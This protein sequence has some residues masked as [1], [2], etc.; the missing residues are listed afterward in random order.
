MITAAERE[1]IPLSELHVD[2]D[3]PESKL[4]NFAK[5]LSDL[6]RSLPDVPLTIT[7]LP[8]WL[9]HRSEFR[10]L[11]ES[12]SSYVLQVHSLERPHGSSEN[13]VLC[14]SE[15]AL[16][17]VR[18]A[19][20]FGKPF[21]VAL[22]TYSYLIAFDN[23][24]QFAGI[25][26]EQSWSAP[27]SDT[28]VKE[29]RSLPSEMARLVRELGNCHIAALTGVI[30]Y[31]LP[32]SDDQ[33]N[34]SWATLQSVTAG[35]SPVSSLKCEA[36][37]IRPALYEVILRNDG[38]EQFEGPLA[39]RLTAPEATILARDALGSFQIRDS[40][41]NLVVLESKD[42]IQPL[43]PLAQRQ[44]GWVRVGQQSEVQFETKI[45]MH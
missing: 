23:K 41:Q 26:A 14:D 1:N 7:T 30:W 34:W 19:G 44:I 29:V 8:A 38:S 35:Q 39:V 22:P 32:T 5:L 15:S 12:V 27:K 33:L 16:K 13:L 28:L 42:P 17:A 25:R 45:T 31:R 11:T 3:C 36:R 2:F 10:K 18:T 21:L 40:T 4:S 37:Q 6:K 24:G 9:A 20:T 43:R